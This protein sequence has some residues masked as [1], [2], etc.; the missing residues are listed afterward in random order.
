M[1]QYDTII[2]G[3][4]CGGLSAALELADRGKRV[5]VLERQPRAGGFAT[6]FKRRGFT[7]EASVHCV[8]DFFQGSEI[9]DFLEK[10][11]VDKA[12]EF[13]P[14]NDFMRIIYPEHDF[15]ADFNREH[16]EE[17]LRNN[18]PAERKNIDR[19]FCDMDIFFSHFDR[20][21]G[22][23]FTSWIQFLATFLRSLKVIQVAPLTI[24]QYL[25]TCIRDK[26]LKAIIANLWYFFGLAPSRLSALYFLLGFRGYYYKKTVY[27]KGGFD[28]LFEAMVT[29]IKARGG[30]VYFNTTVAQIITQPGKRIN[31]VTTDKGHIY[32]AKTVI[33]NASAIGTLAELLDDDGIKKKY[34][35]QL[36]L[37]EQSTSA[38]QV[39][40]GLSVPA[41]TLGMDHFMFSVNEA[42]DHDK[43]FDYYAQQDFAH[44]PFEMVDHSQ[45]DATLAPA[46][47]GTLSIIAFDVYEKWK[48]LT[49]EEYAKKKNT[50]ADALIKRA[51]RYLPGLS[52]AVEVKEVAT[53]LTMERFTLS[54]RGSIYGFAQTVGQSGMNRVSLKTKVKGLFLAGAWTRPGAGVHACFISGL[55]AAGAALEF[56]ESEAD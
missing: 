22:P 41:K 43:N 38:F 31:A 2:I 15:V 12:V 54:P 51:E 56:L 36:S 19:L 46:G 17:F 49:A 13:I 40:L 27:V 23:T 10:T 1:A 9:R 5:L 55:D 33:S 16:F 48:G 21:T 28:K 30:E 8:D 3:A 26:K 52:K 39:Y 34:R 11:G 53:P 25:S 20:L 4:G 44:C 24:E 32:K 14:L 45:L 50:L 42:Y 29:K 47:K 37:L 7:F 18:F 35:K 6:T